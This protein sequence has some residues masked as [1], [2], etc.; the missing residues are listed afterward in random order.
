MIFSC[1]PDEKKKPLGW[2]LIGKCGVE[3]VSVPEKNHQDTSIIEFID[4]KTFR[5]KG[6]MYLKSEGEYKV[7]NDTLQIVYYC[8]KCSSEPG[9]TNI[10]CGTQY[11]VMETTSTLELVRVTDLQGKDRPVNEVYMGL[12]IPISDCK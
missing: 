1:A 6:L 7:V 9:E 10:C 11:Y 2:D 5:R 3:I 12:T 4:E 8:N